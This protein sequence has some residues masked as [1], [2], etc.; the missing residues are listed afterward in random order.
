MSIA[1][2]FEIGISHV[3]KTMNVLNV[4]ELYTLKL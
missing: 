2:L 1:F 4:I 3:H